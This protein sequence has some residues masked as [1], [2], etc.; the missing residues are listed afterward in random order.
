[1]PATTY[2]LPPNTILHHT[3]GYLDS[4]PPAPPVHLVQ[5]DNTLP[6]LAVSLYAGGQPY[7]VPE[8]AYVNIRMTKPDGT[9]IYN[10]ALGVD[11]ARS[12]AYIQLTPQMTVLDG[13]FRPILEITANGGVAGTSVLSMHIDPNPV[14]EEKIQS[15]DEFLTVQQLAAQAAQAAASAA[16]SAQAAANS[17]SAAAGSETAAGGSKDSAAGSASSAAANAD[18]AAQD[19]AQAAQDAQ[20]AT[21]QANAA[22]ASAQAAQEAAEQAQS[23]VPGNYYTKDETQQ[24]VDTPKNLTMQLL[25]S[26]DGTEGK[27]LT[28][29]DCGDA[30]LLLVYFDTYAPNADFGTYFIVPESSNESDVATVNTNKRCLCYYKFNNHKFTQTYQGYYPEGSSTI[31][32]D[33][34]VMIV[35]KI[36]ALRR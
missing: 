28:N 31:E 7:T 15:E 9:V 4:R 30:N 2:T 1:M 5:Y 6:V 22:A 14:K 35:R 10:P 11:A 32:S 20:T 18:Q 33:N 12:T 3:E 19:A 25:Y 21:E 23:F 17:Q 29:F 8:N 16:A 26:Y 34:T 36:Y 27:T 24:L 13:D